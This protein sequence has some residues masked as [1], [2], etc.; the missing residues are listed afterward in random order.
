[1]GLGYRV[2]LH[3]YLGFRSTSTL[4]YGER[5]AIL[6]DATQL[7]SDAHRLAA[8]LIL[9][10]KNL[11][12]IYVSHF[13]PYEEVYATAKTGAELA[14]RIRD[15]Y[16]EVQG[17]DFAIDWLARLLFPKSSPEWFTPLPGE[18]GKIFLNPFGTYDG[19]PQRE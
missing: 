7:L 5:D 17:N 18:P 12:H 14:A 1:M 6:V 15:R 8:E 13:H 3:S 2:F 11:T 4:F 9:L 16:P 10:R 19:D